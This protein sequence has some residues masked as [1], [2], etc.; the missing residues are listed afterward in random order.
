MEQDRT[1]LS[2]DQRPAGAEMVSDLARDIPPFIAM[3]VLE[4]AQAMQRAGRSIVQVS[5]GEPD[6]ETPAPIVEAA[7]RALDLGQTHYTHSMGLPEL[8][9]E[10]AA[11]YHR[12]YGVTISPEQVVVSS[13]TSPLLML[14]F[15][16][17]C[18]PGDEVIISDPHYAC[19][20]NAIRSAGGVP[21]KVR[22]TEEGGFRFDLG[23]LRAAVTPRT[24][25]ILVNSPS[26]P[27]G[28]V[29]GPDDLRALAGV[30]PLVIS[31]EIYHGLVYGEREHSMLEFTDRTVV[32]NGFSKAYAMTGWRLGYVI[33]PKELV[34]PVQKL[35][36]N[37]FICASSFGQLAAITALRQGEPFTKQMA[38]AYDERRRFMLRRLKEMGL[39]I[40]VEPT[41][42]FYVLANARH[43]HPDSYALAFDIL[44]RV[45]VATVPGIDFGHG[46]EGYLRL[47][48][49]T[50]MPKIAEAMDRLETY[51][52]DPRMRPGK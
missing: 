47:S 42:A 25:A 33:L 37:L 29:L 23:D 38:A 6:F 28:I 8:R 40:K 19:Y 3:D 45:G 15:M 34:R 39:G 49:A 1:P 14:V 10:I 31:D 20:P 11:H 7:K 44:E 12:R 36:Q 4:K 46:A 26:N 51:V 17:I 30:G 24:K 43:I 13:G 21:V 22:V 41:G 48:Y 9:E 16:A 32:I 52:R 18:D 2:N 50:A 5:A 27:T 35:Q